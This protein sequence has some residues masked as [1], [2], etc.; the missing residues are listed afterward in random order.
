MISKAVL[1]F[2]ATCLVLL[3]LISGPS[4]AGATWIAQ[5][6]IDT[7]DP[8]RFEKLIKSLIEHQKYYGALAVAARMTV[9]LTDL[10]SKELA[11]KTM[12]SLVDQGY[13]Y[14]VQSLFVPADIE[15][16]DPYEF[17]NGYNLYKYLLNKD[18]GLERW[19]QRYLSQIDK[20]NFYK[21]QFFL[22]LQAYGKNDLAT[23]EDLL[24]KILAKDLPIEQAPFVRKA[25]RT[26]ARIY[27]DQE[28]YEKSLDI[29]T[30]VL[31][32]M[33]P[34]TTSDWL[35]TAWNYYHLKK[36][37][38]TLGILYNLESRAARKDLNL[39]KY[40]IRALVYRAICST[41]NTETLI[42]TFDRD[43]GNVIS[44][45]RRGEPLA[46]YPVLTNIDI[47]ENAEYRQILST[48]IELQRE[49]GTIREI[50]SDLQPTANYIYDS[51]IKMLR[52]RIKSYTGKALDNAA[53]Q[54]IILA[55]RLRFLKFD[56][57]REKFNPDAV[58]QNAD[59]K[60]KPLI[61]TS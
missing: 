39:E 20:D 47:R 42:G 14:S 34:I 59:D 5:P 52:Q 49:W 29:Y 32:K 30:S 2:S 61:D 54:L 56:V 40:T 16:Q 19:S 10:Q 38:E 24:K 17:V 48:I 7:S 8:K 60:S 25:A 53:A 45:I 12:I 11:Y 6:P 23:A 36:Y 21:Y 44:G 4:Y 15:P 55:E 26:L 50:S 18:K 31:L 46:K 43:F 9:F 1:R 51:E 3:G 35:E 33:N 27:F 41:E 28:K 22:A 13:P 57:A 37:P 58:F